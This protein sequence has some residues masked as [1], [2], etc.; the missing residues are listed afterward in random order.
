[1]WATGT[2]HLAILL[3]FSFVVTTAAYPQN[4]PGGGRP[5]ISMPVNTGVE[6]SNCVNSSRSAAGL[7]RF[8]RFLESSPFADG[9]AGERDTSFP[10]GTCI[11]AVPDT[12][13]RSPCLVVPG[14]T[15]L[16]SG[17]GSCADAERASAKPLTALG[18]EGVK[19]NGAREQVAAILSTPNA[20]AEWFKSKDPSPAQTLQSLSF[21]VDRHGPAEI[22]ESVQSAGLLTLRHP[23]VASAIQEGGPFTTVTI[24]AYG[25]FYRSQGRVERID[26]D[27][28]PLRLDGLR[29]LTVGSYEG[30][31]LA[32]QMLTLLHELG[33]VID[34][35]PQDGDDL[36][37]SSLRNTNEVLRHCRPE[38]DAHAQEAKPAKS[39]HF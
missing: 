8:E 13:L 4:V 16:S 39:H 27:G 25:A 11:A 3:A 17:S 30:N 32:A 15:T 12:H 5:A 35:L 9:L 37:G 34:L 22:L 38:L 21:Q 23:Y 24:N 1:M 28:G 2:S 19:I 26:T 7:W 29:T 6:R 14:A 33:H 10:N 20:C 18:K 31:T 36:D